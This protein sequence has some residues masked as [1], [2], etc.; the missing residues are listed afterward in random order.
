MARER[1]GFHHVALGLRRLADAPPVLVGILGGVP[2]LAARGRGFNFAAWRF[3]TGSRVEALE[4]AGD[5]GFLHRFLARR[6]PGI[7]HVTFKVPGLRAAC[8]RAEARGYAIV[9]RDESRPSW[10]EAFLHPRQA[11]GIVVQFAES[12]GP[13]GPPAPLAVPPGPPDPPP[14]VR[15]VGLRTRARSVERARVQWGEIL[16]ATA[17]PEEAAAAGAALVFRWPGSPMR[18]VV[19]VAP[20][21]AEGPVGI[22]VAAGRP[23]ALAGRPLGVRWLVTA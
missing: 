19:E 5:D 14:P 22:E 23:L 6:G 18:I 4:P 11:L 7:H 17:C 2:E 12:A 8:A 1:V 9:G 20:D 3:A 21:A 10:Q 13:G 15:V 16:E